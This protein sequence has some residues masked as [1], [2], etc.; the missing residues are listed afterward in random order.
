MAISISTSTALD[1]VTGDR[2][3][4]TRAAMRGGLQRRRA[5]PQQ[6]H[7]GAEQCRCHEGRAPADLV[8]KEGGDNRRQRHAQVAEYAVDADDPAGPVAGGLHQHRGADRVV[9]RGEQADPAQREPQHQGRARQCGGEQRKRGAE[10]ERAHQH[11]AAEPLCQPALRQ[12]DQAVEHEHAGRQRQDRPVLG[13]E[14]PAGACHHQNCGR[15][16]QQAVMGHG[17]GRVDED[18]LPCGGS[19]APQSP[20]VRNRMV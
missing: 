4:G 1:E 8:G 11:L 19:H 18:D 14:R 7:R 9:D 16:D 20:V 15:Q 6:A 5:Q 2:R 3:E 10:E 12:R 17:V 13:A